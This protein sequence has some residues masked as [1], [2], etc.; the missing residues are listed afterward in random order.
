MLDNATVSNKIDTILI[1]SYETNFYYPFLI[2]R[3][4]V[5]AITPKINQDS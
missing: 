1:E 5:L 3:I 2:K 4:K